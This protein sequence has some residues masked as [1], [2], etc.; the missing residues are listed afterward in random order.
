MTTWLGAVGGKWDVH[1]IVE[2]ER[3]SDAQWGL[4]VSNVPNP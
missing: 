2:F 1:V 4:G 3:S